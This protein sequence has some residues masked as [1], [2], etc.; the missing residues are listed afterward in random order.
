[1]KEVDSVINDKLNKVREYKRTI[2]GDNEEE[3]K[4]KKKK[5][6]TFV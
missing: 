6:I 2:L 1:M 4:G 3:E 5:K